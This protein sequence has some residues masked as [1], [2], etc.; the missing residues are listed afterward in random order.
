MRIGSVTLVNPFFMA[1]MAG[2]TRMPFRIILK[3]CG[4][5]LV[6]TEMVMAN[7]LVRENPKTLIY[8]K[9]H[10]AEKPLSVQ[11]CGSEPWIMGEA[12]R[13][14]QESGADL[15]DINM[16]C[17]VRKVVRARAGAAL[18]REPLLA[19]RVVQAVVSAVQIPVTVKM[20]AGWSASCPNA[21]EMAALAEENGAKGVIVHGRTVAQAYAGS[22]SH[23]IIA[24][25][26]R[27]VQIPVIG[28]GN[29]LTPED[30][31][32]MM[33]KTGCDG[34][35]VARGALGNPW[36]FRGLIAL[37]RGEPCS[38]PSPEERKGTLLHHLEAEIALYGEYRAI[39]FMRRFAS[40]YGKGMR[41]V[42]RFRNRINR[43]INKRDMIQLIEDFFEGRLPLDEKKPGQ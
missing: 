12:A 27:R 42:H 11:I 33:A 18:M 38:P 3:N 4:A 13:R 40:L 22:V 31:I 29:I 8:L 36:I 9:G 34:I 35:M 37:H 19:R 26:K 32:A 24:E 30:G 23:G 43:V 5:G 41:G 10:P 16:G 39:R 15:I 17:P 6:S 1:P 28:N 21:P 14:V 2:L 25:V 20:R 7:A